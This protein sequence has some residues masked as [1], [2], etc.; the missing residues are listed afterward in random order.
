MPSIENLLVSF[1]AVSW[2]LGLTGVGDGLE[3]EGKGCFC[4]PDKKR[5]S[6]GD[7]A[8]SDSG[9]ARQGR[10]LSQIRSNET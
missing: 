2:C 8:V 5:D 10:E 9:R 3:W 6:L 1:W 4:S 7:R